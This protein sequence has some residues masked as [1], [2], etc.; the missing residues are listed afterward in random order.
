[1]VALLYRINE[2]TPF[3]N[4]QYIESIIYQVLFYGVLRSN[5]DILIAFFRV[6]DLE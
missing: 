5:F 4:N 3:I 2:V 6:K 1:V